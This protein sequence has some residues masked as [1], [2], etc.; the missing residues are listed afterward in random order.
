M[1][2]KVSKL[3]LS[4]DIFDLDVWVKI[5]PVINQS[6]ATLWVRDASLIVGLLPFMIT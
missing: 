2:K 6:S 1:A 4:V 5:D 3:V